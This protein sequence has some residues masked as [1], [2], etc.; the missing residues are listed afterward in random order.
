VNGSTGV[1]GWVAYNSGTFNTVGTLSVAGRIQ[2]SDA[3]RNG[4]GTPSNKKTLE[5]GQ[6]TLTS[7]GVID[8]NDNDMIIRS[9]QSAQ[10]TQFIRTARNGGLWNQAGITSTAAKNNPQHNTT[11]G[12]LSGAEYSGANG[13]T[14]QF[15]GRT[16]APSD[17]LVKYTYYGD[18]DFNGKVN[19]DDYVRTDNG[20]NGHLS[21]W[22]NGDFDGN[23]VVNFDDYVL[24]DLAFN[25]QTGTL[26]RVVDGLRAGPAE[27]RQIVSAGM[28]AELASASDPARAHMAMTMVEQHAAQFGDGY[29]NSLLTRAVPEPASG[30]SLL[31]IGTLGSALRR[32]ARR[33]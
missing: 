9:S 12:V 31:A 3:G 26:G 1:D 23:G 30:L 16:I 18:T 22:L 29:V 5:A 32:R 19:F 2:C 8:L 28:S 4:V 33:N 21:G 6:A 13:G 20:F 17:T 7:S 14:T 11:L 25:T 27:D 10:T 15:N 24:I